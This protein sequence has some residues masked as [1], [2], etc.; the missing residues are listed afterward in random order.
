MKV[1]LCAVG[2]IDF[3]QPRNIGCP[4][5]WVEVASYEEASK[6]CRQYIRDNNLGMGN[7]TGGTIK[8]RARKVAYV[9]YNGRVWLTGDG[10]RCPV[11]APC[12]FPV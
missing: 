6:A 3:G 8:D 10:P 5:H 9:S 11:G 12:V 2:N 4:S 7:W 1:Q